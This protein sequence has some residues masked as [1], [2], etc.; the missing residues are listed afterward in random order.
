MDEL[1]ALALNQKLTFYQNIGR[2]HS[3]KICII[4]GNPEAFESE[5]YGDGREE[6]MTIRGTSGFV[7]RFGKNC[8]QL[9]AKLWK[10]EKWSTHQPTHLERKSW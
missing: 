10:K 3:S 2:R 1:R 7:I 8:E 5:A 4:H 9:A 6:L